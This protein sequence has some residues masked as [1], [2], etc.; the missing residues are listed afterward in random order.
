MGELRRFSLG[1][2]E[3]T[4]AVRDPPRITSGFR[5]EPEVVRELPR[6]GLAFRVQSGAVEAIGRPGGARAYRLPSLIAAVRD[7]SGARRAG[8]VGA[9]RRLSAADGER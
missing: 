6:I 9:L 8:P 5:Q 3:D 4:G 7:Q 2:R 1:F